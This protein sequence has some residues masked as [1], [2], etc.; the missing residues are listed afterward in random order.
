MHIFTYSYN[1]NRK[2]QDANDWLRPKLINVIVHQYFALPVL[3]HD[4]SGI[5]FKHIY[6]INTSVLL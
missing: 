5:K 2:L 3:S 4:K 1:I 6:Y